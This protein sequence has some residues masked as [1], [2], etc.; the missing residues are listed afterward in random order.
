MVISA[1]DKAGNDLSDIANNN[2]VLSDSNDLTN[3]ANDLQC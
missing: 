1:N 2:D 3:I